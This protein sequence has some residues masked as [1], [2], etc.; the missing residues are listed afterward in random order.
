MQL[1]ASIDI[2]YVESRGLFVTLTYEDPYPADPAVWHRNIR[3]F[4]AALERR[5]GPYPIIWRLE[6]QERGAPHFHLILFGP[7]FIPYDWITETWRRIAL[8]DATYQG[9]YAT[10]VEKPR[11]YR[12]SC[13][14]LAK[15]AAKKDKSP[16]K[17]AAGRTW[18]VRRG[19]LLPITILQATI[20]QVSSR[21]LKDGLIATMDPDKV[22]KWVKVGHGGVWTMLDGREALIMSNQA[23][24][25]PLRW[26]QVDP[27]YPEGLPGRR[28]L[29][30]A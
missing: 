14:Y 12:Q 28:A 27:D 17:V 16:A 15:Y 6:Y 21:F 10:R 4:I 11:N 5:D 18:G 1:F 7:E 13:Y 22:N 9:K 25:L 8:P 3:A 19:D 30:T 2:D 23:S 26:E 24:D 29:D 20:D